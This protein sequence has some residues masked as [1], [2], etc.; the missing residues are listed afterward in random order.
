MAG[1]AQGRT[2]DDQVTFYRN[3][4][5]QGLQF[6]SVAQVVHRRALERGVGQQLP[7]EWFLQDVRE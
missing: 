3:V 6:S 5:N 4:G 1:E 2:R 7:S